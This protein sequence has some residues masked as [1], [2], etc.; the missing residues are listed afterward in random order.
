MTAESHPS[1]RELL[2]RTRAGDAEAFGDFYRARR[3]VVLAFLR[4]RVARAELAADLMCETFVAALSAVH[5]RE[6]ELPEIPVAWLV[7][8]ARNQ[9]IDSIR[10]GRIEDGARRRLALQPLELRDHDIDAIEEAAA[11]ADLIAELGSALAADQ[12]HAFIARVLED[13]SYEDIAGELQCSPSVVRKRV[14]RALA[15]L[16]SSRGGSP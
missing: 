11:E 10:R 7:T 12:L 9:L 8:I 15:H 16:R 3:G 4:P 13:R 6:R 2:E 1:D 5:A 14:S